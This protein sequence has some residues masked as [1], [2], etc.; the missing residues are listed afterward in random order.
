MHMHY[1]LA[2]CL[3]WPIAPDLVLI[4][5]RLGHMVN[6]CSRH[7]SSAAGLYSSVTAAMPVVLCGACSIY[8]EQQACSHPPR[9]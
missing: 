3:A 9:C 7:I 8:T 4:V 1:K 2:F 5:S 6:D